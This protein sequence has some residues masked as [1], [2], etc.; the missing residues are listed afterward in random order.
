[1]ATTSYRKHTVA[2]VFDYICNNEM[3][4]V[5]LG[6]FLNYWWAYAVDH[7]RELIEA[8]LAPAP[9]PELHR[10]AAFCAAMVEWLCWQDHLPFPEW[11][12]QESYKLQEPW[13]LYK[14]WKLRAWQLATTPA[15][16][17]M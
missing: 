11:T 6:N 10:W 5:A 9:T 14:N 1:M 17:K 15:P 12:R 2:K 7:R 4:W 16:F 8:P 13:F 3:P